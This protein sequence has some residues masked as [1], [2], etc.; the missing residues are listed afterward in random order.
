MSYLDPIKQK[1]AAH[2]SYLRNKEKIRIRSNLWKHN[3]PEITR[4][5]NK[6]SREK[7]KEIIT[8]NP[9]PDI[10]LPDKKYLMS[11][12]RLKDKLILEVG[13]E[14]AT[15]YDNIRRNICKG[16]STLT[17]PKDE[18]DKW[19]D[20]FFNRCREIQRVEALREEEEPVSAG[21]F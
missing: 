15:W 1:Q 17:L 4:M 9:I 8:S 16:I 13:Q 3:H 19:F 20:M 7:N 21:I 6:L 18:R 5:S 2:E 12:A 11:L 10:S 14:T